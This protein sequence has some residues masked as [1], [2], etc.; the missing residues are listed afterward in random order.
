MTQEEAI[1]QM[2]VF[3]EDDDVEMRHINSDYLLC[4]ILCQLGWEDLVHEYY[5]IGKWYA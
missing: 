3:A 5:K 4:D 2:K 1:E